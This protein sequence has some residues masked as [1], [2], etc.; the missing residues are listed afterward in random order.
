MNMETEPTNPFGMA[1]YSASTYGDSF[2]DVYDEWYADLDDADF[3]DGL[4]AALPQSPTRILELGVGT[5]R[6]ISQLLAL[7][8]HVTDTIIGVDSSTPMLE[9]ASIRAFPPHVFLQQGD[10]SATL[11]EGQF[12]LI[13]VGYNTLFNLPDEDAMRSCFRLV[14]QQLS[15]Q[16]TFAID[17]VSPLADQPGDHV[18]VRTMATHEVVIAISTH[19]ASA[20]RITGQFIQF[21]DGATA[22]LRP[23]S[24]RYFTPT[25]LD[26]LATEAG[27]VLVTR[28]ADGI[29]TEYTPDSFRH[30]SRYSRAI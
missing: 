25:Q 9:A 27:L 13:F 19:D 18:S 15:P 6:L 14:A 11:P 1:G 4:A 5:G 24:V 3:V 23:W 12:D 30:V 17:V 21:A 8:S 20:Q 16:G 7:R 22:R 29:G 10:F 26:A 28:H 2:A